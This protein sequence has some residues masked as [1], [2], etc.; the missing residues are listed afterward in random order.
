MLLYTEMIKSVKGKR[1]YRTALRKEQAQLTRRRILDA[2]RRLL[3]GGTYSSLTM[4]EIAKEAGVAYQ[5]VYS[6]FGTKLQLA[7]DIIESGFPHVEDALKLLDQ[8]RDSP[9]DPELWLRTVARVSRRIYEPCADLN[10]FMRESGDPSLL[11]RYRQSEEQRF[12]GI[13]QQSGLEEVLERSGRLRPGKSA[14]EALVTI[15]ALSGP[16]LYSQ[17]VFEKGWTP[18][19]YEEWLGDALINMLL[20]PA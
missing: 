7:R 12:I 8:L 6:N 5:T 10:R 17:L 19:H 16:D 14:S 1:T 4:G 13:T 15:W 9:D 11:A 18:T 3:A 20:E 2:G